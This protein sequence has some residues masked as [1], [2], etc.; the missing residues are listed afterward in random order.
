MVLSFLKKQKQQK[1]IHSDTDLITKNPSPALSEALK[2]A[3]TNLMYS[4]ADLDDGKCVILTSALAAE[5]KTTTCINLAA[6]LAQTESRVLLVDADMRRPR[7]HKYLNIL[8]KEGLANYLG[9]FCKLEDIICRSEELNLDIV[10]AGNLP[11]NPTELLSSKKMQHFVATAKEQYD[12]ILFDTPPV[13]IVAD[14][15][16]LTRL[17]ENTVFVCKC[18]VSVMKEMK[19]AVS[20]LKF[21]NAK[22][23]GFISI[24]AYAKKKRTG[25]YSGY[26]YYQES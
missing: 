23:L 16:A 10:T 17:V 11:P 12:Y 15:V 19:K 4:L 18:G 8:N 1:H 3:R 20:S 24:D 5:G 26:Y 22:I 14:A 9:G 13:N 21:A 2:T 7:V 25:N 6:S